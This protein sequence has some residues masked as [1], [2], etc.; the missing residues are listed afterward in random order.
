MK[1]LIIL[2]M[3]LIIPSVAFAD[4][5]NNSDNKTVLI[6]TVVRITDWKVSFV[7]PGTC[8]ENS[9]FF[10]KSNRSELLL[11]FSH[12]SFFFG[13]VND[14]NFKNRL[15]PVIISYK[16]NN[17]FKQKIILFN[18]TTLNSKI[19]LNLLSKN[20]SKNLLVDLLNIKELYIFYINN[21]LRLKY[22]LTNGFSLPM[23]KLINCIKNNIIKK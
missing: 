13:I 7:K 17:K 14:G 23:P 1:K 22:K 15:I 20:I 3:F 8:F 11:G 2:L 21:G 16:V 4:I 18:R 9:M 12:G 5:N 6:E 19:N 10:G